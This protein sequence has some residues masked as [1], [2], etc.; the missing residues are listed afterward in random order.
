MLRCMDEQKWWEWNCVGA[1]FDWLSAAIRIQ[2]HEHDLHDAVM[3]VYLDKICS[4]HY[5][6][7]ERVFKTIRR[8]T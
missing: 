7:N 1:A 8:W 3:F 6:T 2:E 5:P 4:C